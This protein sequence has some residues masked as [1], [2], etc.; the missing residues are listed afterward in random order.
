M[1]SNSGGCCIM[2]G[3]NQNGSQATWIFNLD[4]LARNEFSPAAGTKFISGFSNSNRLLT[5]FA[6]NFCVAEKH[7]CSILIHQN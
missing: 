4:D 2:V 6:D 3:K 7:N 5:N 1:G